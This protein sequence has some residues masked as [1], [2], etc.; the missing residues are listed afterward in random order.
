MIS[1]LLGL[2]ISLAALVWGVLAL[3]RGPFRRPE[4][5][6][7]HAR[8]FGA[9]HVEN[10]ERRTVLTAKFSIALGVLGILLNLYAL[11]RVL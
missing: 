9:E 8:Q 6:D 5:R 4:D 2:L 7:A 3:R 1:A 10:A 11:V